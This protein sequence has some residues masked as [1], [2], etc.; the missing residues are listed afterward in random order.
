VGF[1]ERQIKQ[2]IKEQEQL[3]KEQEQLELDYD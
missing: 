1:D 2:Y 3:Q